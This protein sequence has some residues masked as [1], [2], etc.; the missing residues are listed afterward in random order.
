MI[1]MLVYDVEETTLVVQ[2]C[3][4]DPKAI[5]VGCSPNMAVDIRDNLYILSLSYERVPYEPYDIMWSDISVARNIDTLERI[6]AFK[7]LENVHLNIFV[8]RKPNGFNLYVFD[9]MSALPHVV[10]IKK[11]NAKSYISDVADYFSED[12]PDVEPAKD[13]YDKRYDYLRR[14]LIMSYLD[15]DDRNFCFEAGR[16]LGLFP[17]SKPH[18]I[19]YAGACK[20]HRLTPLLVDEQHFQKQILKTPNKT[21][22]VVQSDANY[23]TPELQLTL[24]KV[25]TRYNNGEYDVTLFMCHALY[26]KAYNYLIDAGFDSNDIYTYADLL[27]LQ[28]ESLDSQLDYSL[29]SACEIAIKLKNTKNDVYTNWAILCNDDMASLSNITNLNLSFED[30]PKLLPY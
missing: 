16:P 7:L 26:E 20:L 8:L 14:N 4:D 29:T 22:L 28:N 25:V 11:I 19:V 15:K 9:G 1:P 23:F 12:V 21:V 13:I 27:Y 2:E 18:L 17:E 6:Q 30:R 3:Y 5:R 24:D 10:F